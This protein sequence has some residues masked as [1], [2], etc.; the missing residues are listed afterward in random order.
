MKR[1]NLFFIEHI[2]RFLTVFVC[3]VMAAAVIPGVSAPVFAAEVKG[4]RLLIQVQGEDGYRV[5]E[6]SIYYLPPNTPAGIEPRSLGKTDAR[7]ELV[8][9]ELEEVKKK[10]KREL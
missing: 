3:L 9:T 4:A 7:G 1:E 5:P 6:L 10:N 8:F 2:R